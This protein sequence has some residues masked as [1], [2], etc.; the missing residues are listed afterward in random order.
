MIDPISGWTPSN[1][2]DIN[3]SGQIVG[4]GVSPSGETHAFLLTPVPTPSSFAALIGMGL[5]GMVAVVRRRKK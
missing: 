4:E 2:Y 5:M 1:A 3:D